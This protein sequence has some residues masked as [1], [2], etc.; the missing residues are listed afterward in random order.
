[1]ENAILIFVHSGNEPGVGG[2]RKAVEHAENEERRNR[3]RCGLR[4]DDMDEAEQ[5]G[6]TDLGV[7]FIGCDGPKAESGVSVLA[8]ALPLLWFR[9]ELQNSAA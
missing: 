8:S 6:D 5:A 1:M 2:V 9:R 7:S 3:Q 4:M